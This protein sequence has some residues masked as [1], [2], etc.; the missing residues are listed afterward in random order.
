MTCTYKKKDSK[1]EENP[2]RTHE[3]RM[4]IVETQDQL[5]NEGKDDYLEM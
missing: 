2:S 3:K 4:P 1:K 5:S